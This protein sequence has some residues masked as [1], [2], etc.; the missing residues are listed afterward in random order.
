MK[1]NE[2][3]KMAKLRLVDTTLMPLGTSLGAAGIALSAPN[4]AY[5]FSQMKSGFETITTQHLIPLS[6]AVAGCS[7][8]VYIILSYFKKDEYQKY[9]GN[10]LALSIFARVGLG[11][12]DAITKSFS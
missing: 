6:G 5:A 9:V 11:V 4:N 7:L 8:I 12:I 1:I 3:N 2:S 10:I